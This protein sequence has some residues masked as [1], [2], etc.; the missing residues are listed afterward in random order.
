MHETLKKFID[1]LDDDY[2]RKVLT[3]ALNYSIIGFFYAMFVDRMPH[4]Y[5]A[6]VIKKYESLKL[7]PLK[8]TFHKKANYFRVLLNNKLLFLAVEYLRFKTT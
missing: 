8:K 4:Q 5:V 3:E 2:K 1:N 7:Y 6:N